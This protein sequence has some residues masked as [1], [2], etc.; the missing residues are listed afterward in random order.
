MI[1]HSRL[2]A[3][4]VTV[5]ENIALEATLIDPLGP[6][7]VLVPLLLTCRYVYHSL[8]MHGCPHLYGRIFRSRFD[9]RAA[10]RRLGVRATYSKNLAWQLRKHCLALKRIRRGDIF[11]SNL[12]ADLWVAFIMAVENDGKNIVQ[13]EWA[14]IGSLLHNFLVTRLWENRQDSNGWPAESALNALV[15]WLVWF[16]LDDAKLAAITPEKRKQIMDLI[17]PY[18]LTAARYPSF[19]APDNHFDF[20]LPDELQNA[21]PYTLMTPHGFYPLYRQPDALIERGRRHFNLP[22]AISPPLIAQGAKLLYMTLSG[23]ML[24]DIPSS[25]PLNRE[26]AIQLGRTHVCLTQAD[27]VEVNAHKSV[28]LVDRGTWEWRAALTEEEGRLEDDGVWRRGLKG[29][30][31]RWD[32]DWHRLT[33]CTNPWEIP[34][35]KGVVYT[36][37]TLDGQWQGVIQIPDVGQYFALIRSVNFPEDFSDQNPRLST[38]PVYMRLREH[39]CISPEVAVAYGGSPSDYDDGIR[40]GW[41]PKVSFRESHGM[42][43]VDDETHNEVSHYET[44]VEGR[45]N[46]HSEDRCMSCLHRRRLEDEE[47]QMRV[48]AQRRASQEAEIGDGGGRSFALRKETSAA[49]PP[50][51]SASRLP[52]SSP[53]SE[54][55]EDEEMRMAVDNALGPDVNVDELL[56]EVMGESDHEDGSDA[57]D[58]DVDADAYD[59][60]DDR[61][62]TDSVMEYMM[63]TCNGIQDIIVTGETLPRHGQAWHHFRFY[64]RVRKWDGL[65]A[66]VRVPVHYPELGVFIFRGYIVA[67]TNFVGSWRAYTH[68]THA[69]PLEGPFVM[70]KV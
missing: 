41:F 29:P 67:N 63:H 53:M 22:L 32:N 3:I 59:D 14:N 46:S 11:D 56:D 66:I 68:N 39:H 21:F 35:L 37:G 19:H 47:L 4:P 10:F 45:P 7:S 26:H 16:D 20:P 27:L 51:T 18:V 64:G 24:F 62:D 52:S 50:S 70:S 5:L 54:A 61:S 13:L 43:R 9:S 48:H 44:Y 33:C 49:G 31:A 28:K 38:V 12:K 40:N 69:I 6:P 23:T 30:S 57:E 42:V 25:L 58:T 34:E 55:A 60:D 15:I 1:Q 17:R 2:C 36:Y 65:I 8:S